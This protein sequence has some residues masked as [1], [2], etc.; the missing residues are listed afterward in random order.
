[1]DLQGWFSY[2]W[3]YDW[4]ARNAGRDS[5][6]PTFVEVGVWKGASISH[7]CQRLLVE[8]RRPFRLCAVDTWSMDPASEANG[9]QN[10]F[11]ADLRA[12]NRTLYGVYNEN[13]ATLGIRHLITDYRMTS[14]Q[15]VNLIKQADFVFID[16][17]HSADAVAADVEAWRPK[18]AILAGHDADESSVAA[19]LDR[20]LGPGN[21]Y[22]LQFLRCWTTCR[23]L[24]EA[25]NPHSAHGRALYWAEVARIERWAEE[26]AAA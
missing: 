17:D 10:S 15:A 2:D 3:L 20:A 18:A 21:W 26:Y 1:M 9:V 13:M 5:R 7:L 19:G 8:K 24:S 16:G 6:I 11:L 23:E 22:F 12:D 4:A 14:I 25:W